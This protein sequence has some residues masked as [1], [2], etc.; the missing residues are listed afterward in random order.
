MYALGLLAAA[1]EY[2]FVAAEKVDSA[3]SA[4][5]PYRCARGR[6]LDILLGPVEDFEYTSTTAPSE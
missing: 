2:S 4:A 3:L 5:K 1:I 6:V